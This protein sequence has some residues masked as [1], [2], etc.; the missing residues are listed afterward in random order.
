MKKSIIIATLSLF[1]VGSSAFAQTSVK[2]EGDTKANTGFPALNTSLKQEGN[3]I[4]NKEKAKEEQR[5][6]KAEHEAS[7]KALQ[8]QKD[9]LKAE[10]KEIKKQKATTR[11]GYVENRLRQVVNV[12]GDHQA[13]VKLTIDHLT[14]RGVN[15]TEAQKELADS[16]AS[17]TIAIENLDKLSKILVVDADQ[18]TVLEA[19]VFAKNA[20]EALR[21]ARE[22]LVEAI[23]LLKKAAES[24]AST[25]TTIS[26]EDKN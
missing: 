18:K 8:Q 11:K 20:E 1:F 2:I 15:T 13:R 10:I 7:K 22:Q 6:A 16:R 19:R 3:I 4:L 9:A 26:N 17:L 21:D 12:L 24:S 25:S 5:K 23:K 14:L